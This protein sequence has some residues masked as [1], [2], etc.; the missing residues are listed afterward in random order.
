MSRSEKRERRQGGKGVGEERREGGDADINHSSPVQNTSHKTPSHHH[1]PRQLSHF[2]F[3]ILL[4]LQN[5]KPES[6][7][8]GFSGPSNEQEANASRALLLIVCK[9]DLFSS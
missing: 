5:V 7:W 6:N 4:T 2:S 1:N 3:L 9:S 8:G